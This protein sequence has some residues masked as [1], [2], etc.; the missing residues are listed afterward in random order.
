MKA[1]PVRALCSVHSNPQLETEKDNLGENRGKDAAHAQH[2]ARLKGK[3][4]L[5]VGD[6]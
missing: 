4:R 2:A 5:H 1:L 3:K 6:N